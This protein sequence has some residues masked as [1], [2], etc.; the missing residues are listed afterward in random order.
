MRKHLFFV[1]KNVTVD[2]CTSGHSLAIKTLVP[3]NNVLMV[4]K[5]Y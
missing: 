4:N 2:H 3:V 1:S 5:L